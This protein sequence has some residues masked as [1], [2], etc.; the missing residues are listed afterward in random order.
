VTDAPL[1]P[2]RTFPRLRLAPARP[3]YR[4]TRRRNED[5]SA[6]TPWFFSSSGSV[7]AGRFDLPS[8]RGSCY[9]ADQAVGAFVEVYRR[10]LVIARS[11][12]ASRHVVVAMRTGGPLSLANLAS[13][14]AAAFG[15][16]IDQFAGDDYTATQLLAGHLG[17]AGFAGVSAPARHDPSLQSR[18]VALF[19][20]AGPARSQRGWRTRQHD[21]DADPGL[22]AAAREYGYAVLDVPFDVPITQPPRPRRRRQ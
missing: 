10:V 11:D 22:L 3:L 8:P 6:R 15:V 9:F 12:L 20:R 17:G 2:W 1:P 18:T 19:G 13:A 21:I 5:G 14:R 4:I 16:T 7:D